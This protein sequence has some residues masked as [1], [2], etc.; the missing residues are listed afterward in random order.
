MKLTIGIATRGRPELAAW[1]AQIALDNCVADTQ[2]VVL[3]DDDDAPI[4]VPRGTI[5]SVEP[6]PDTI[7]EKWNRMMRVAPADVYMPVCDYRGQ[8]TSGFDL[9]IL[10]AASLFKDGIGCVYQHM[11]NLSF[12]AYQA[13]TAKMARIMGCIYVEHFPY[14][15]VDHWLD[16][17]ARMIGRFAYA[18]GNTFVRPRPGN[19]ST[20]EFREPGFWATLYD[21]QYIERE[22]IAENLMA[23][24]NIEDW[25]RDILRAQWPLVHQRSRMINGIVQNMKGNA[26]FDDRYM[27]IREKGAAKLYQLYQQLEAA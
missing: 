24:M 25:Q 10:D 22:A 2:I 19:G 14:W 12:P 15:F 11:A 21:A 13:V 7:G 6:R 1:A 26:P 9:K 23:E 4:N 17:I 27:R 20:Q 18:D 8:L 5:L 3:A 16:D